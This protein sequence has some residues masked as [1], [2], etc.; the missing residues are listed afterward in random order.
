M[1][2]PSITMLTEDLAVVVVLMDSEQAVAAE[3]TQVEAVEMMNMT[4]VEEEEVPII[5]E[6][7]K[8]M[9]VVITQLAMEM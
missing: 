1:E 8:S 4:P 6:R 2:E 9:T 3:D 5:T 7:S